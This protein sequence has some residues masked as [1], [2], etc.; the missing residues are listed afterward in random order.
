VQMELGLGQKAEKAI[1]RPVE[2]R[3][4]FLIVDS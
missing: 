2:R 3:H 1:R 4:G